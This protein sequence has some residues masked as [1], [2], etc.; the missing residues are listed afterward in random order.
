MLVA[1]SQAEVR[2]VLVAVD[3]ATREQGLH[4]AGFVSYEAA[5]A[6]DRAF[7][8]RS[9]QRLPLAWF[10]L[11]HKYDTSSAEPAVAAEPPSSWAIDLTRA[12]YDAAVARIRAA[13]AEGRTY[14]VNLSARL[15]S[16]F[17][18]DVQAWYEVLRRA[19][20]TGYHALLDLD[21]VVILSA[22]PELF[23]ARRGDVIVTRPMKGTRPRGRYQEEDLARA[24]ELVRA[25][26]DR[27]ENLMIVDLL[28]NDVG[29]IA[30]TG[31]VEVTDLYRLERYP[32]VWQLTS[33]IRGRLPQASGLHDLFRALFPCGSVTG[34]PKISTMQ[35]IAQLERSPREVYCGAIGMVEPGGD[36]TFSVPIRTAWLDR[37]TG[38]V[39]YGA[40]SG[41]VWDSVASLEFDE[42]RAKAAILAEEAPPFELL[43][44]MRL[45]D[46]VFQRVDRHIARLGSSA[47]YFGFRFH[48]DDV[49][50]A[51]A[52]VAAAYPAGAWRVRLLLSAHGEVR[53]EPRA[54]EPQ[55]R[56]A[57]RFDLAY[58]CVQSND[59]F[60]FHKTT[61]RAVHERALAA[62]P[63]LFDVLLWN[64]RGELTEFTRGNVVLEIDGQRFTP[65]RTAGLLAG[66]FRAELLEAQEIREAT[67]RVSDLARATRVW[68]INSVRGWVEVTRRT[69][70]VDA[71]RQALH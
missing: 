61:H 55:T 17:R 50:A 25:E 10:G 48:R 67:L 45:E 16:H 62:R 24:D 42:L 9:G 34:A 65:P 26:K 37:A 51:L 7:V 64:E 71:A 59:R 15:Q 40:G 39:E 47:A 6:F 18:G 28:R 60:L 35:I 14:Q 63:E 23:F 20:G 33:S 56:P 8:V 4:A 46:G 58:R 2:D 49:R 44:T 27:A 19:Q 29:R 21:D 66:T 32:T 12:E 43:E 11:F 30:V 5:P 69:A 36:C 54:L 38:T 57:Q 70:G 22:S 52:R 68:L 31:S 1:H 3:R 13:I 53:S 41:V